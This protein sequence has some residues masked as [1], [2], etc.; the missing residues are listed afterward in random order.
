MLSSN[1][2]IKA[3]YGAMDD[4]AAKSVKGLGTF[5]HVASFLLIL[6]KKQCEA[7]SDSKDHCI[8]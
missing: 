7:G 5:L 1:R 4:I 6:S 3:R 8:A 2:P